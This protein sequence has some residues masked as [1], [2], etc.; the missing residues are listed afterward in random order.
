MFQVSVTRGDV[1]QKAGS[2]MHKA[3]RFTFGFFFLS[4]FCFLLLAFRLASVK[5]K[6]PGKSRSPGVSVFSVEET[7]L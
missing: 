3:R 4:A 1:T 5:N 6:T 2:V 7:L